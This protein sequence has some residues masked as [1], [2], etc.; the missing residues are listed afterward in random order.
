MIHSL[1]PAVP[2]G[3]AK[4]IYAVADIFGII[5]AG[6]AHVLLSKLFPDHRSIIEEAVLAVDVLG[7]GVE[8]YASRPG[9]ESDK[10]KELS[11]M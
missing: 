2:I 10:E 7:G 6:T 5:L 4:Y 8:G 1:N 3:G 11:E 9:S